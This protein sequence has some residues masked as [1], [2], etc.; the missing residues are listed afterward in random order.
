MIALNAQGDSDAITLEWM[1]AAMEMVHRVSA[2]M[3]DPGFGEVRA[4]AQVHQYRSELLRLRNILERG[5]L[6][7]LSQRNI[8]QS[9]QSRLRR[10]R[11]LTEMVRAVQ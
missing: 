3:S 7:L 11:E 9:E 4:S 2:I 8:I 1:T 10:I 5:G 6:Q